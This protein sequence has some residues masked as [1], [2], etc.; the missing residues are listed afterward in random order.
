MP[1]SS[2]THDGRTNMI[3][4][5][6]RDICQCCKYYAAEAPIQGCELLDPDN[7]W[8]CVQFDASSPSLIAGWWTMDEHTLHNLYPI[9]GQPKTDD[10]SDE[11]DFRQVPCLLYLE[12]VM[13]TQ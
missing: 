8:C 4:L 7:E 6:R 2:G 1:V 11:E 5:V 13:A 3:T 10:F 9:G 12:Y